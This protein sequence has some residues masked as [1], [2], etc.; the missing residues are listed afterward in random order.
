VPKDQGPPPIHLTISVDEARSLLNVS[1]VHQR[2]MGPM[3]HVVRFTSSREVRG[4]FAF[5]DEES[6]VLRA[7]AQSMVTQAR[8]RESGSARIRFTPRSLIAFWG[9][10]LSST[11]SPRS[12]RH[13]SAEELERRQALA[14]K[15]EEAARALG[16]RDSSVLEEEI[17]GRRPAEQ[18]WMRERLSPPDQ[19]AGSRLE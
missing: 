7:F 19:A 16:R 11:Q 8:E 10:L 6:K 18:A 1:D 17:A 3:R 12:R 2:S 9:R 5:L 14:T 4:R 15:L 13:L